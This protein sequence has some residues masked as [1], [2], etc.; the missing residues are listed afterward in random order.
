MN[1]ST[2]SV[3][4]NSLPGFSTDDFKTFREADNKTHS[5]YVE[6]KL[7]QLYKKV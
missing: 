5:H 6:G 4:R 2:N 3:K 1:F 7:K